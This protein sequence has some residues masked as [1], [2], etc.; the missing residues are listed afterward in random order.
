MLAAHRLEDIYVPLRLKE[1]G[2]VRVLD[3]DT[4]MQ[5]NNHLLILG[6]P[7]AG[8]TTLLK[9]LALQ[10]GAGHVTLREFVHSG[11]SLRDYKA[12]VLLLD[13][14]DELTSPENRAQALG[15]IHRFVEQY[16]RCRMVVTSRPTVSPDQLRGFSRLR[17]LEFDGQQIGQFIDN[18]SGSAGRDRANLL[19][20][21]LW[22]HQ[23]IESLAKNPLLLSVMA[24][25][26]DEGHDLMQGCAPL[27]ERITHLMLGLWDAH[28]K[29][30]NR[31][32]ADIKRFVL[33]K[34]AFRS[35]RLHRH[36]ITEEEIIEEMARHSGKINLGQEAFFPLLEEIWQRSGLLWPVSEESYEFFHLSFQ[37]YFTALEFTE[38]NDRLSPIIPYLYKP[39][40]ETPTLLYMEISRQAAPFI[41]R[42]QEEIPEDIFYSNLMLS[43][44]CLAAAR[45]PDPV[46]KGEIVQS[47]WQFYHNSEF[48][49]LKERAISVLGRLK[50]RSI[51][52][53]QVDKLTDNEPAVR[54]QAAEMLGLIGGTDTLTPLFMVLARD[55]DLKVRSSAASA[56][57]RVGSPEVVP[58][59]VNALDGDKEGE[60]R[61]SVAEA[62]GY[63]GSPAALPALVKALSV[64]RDNRVRGGA[65][66]A[67][68]KIGNPR[69]LSLLLQAFGTEQEVSVRWRIARSLGY[70]AGIDARDVLIAALVH[71]KNKEVRESAAE[72]LGMIGSP[73]C[74]KPLLQTLSSDRDGDVRGSAAYALGLIGSAEAVPELIKTFTTDSDV[75]VRGRAAF[76]LGRLKSKAA[77]PHLVSIFNAHKSSMFRGN[78]AYAL[79]EIAAE[80]AVP[81]LI[82]VLTLDADPYVRYRSAEV[83]GKI[84]DLMTVSPLKLALEDDGSY[85]GWKVKDKAFEALENLSQRLDIRINKD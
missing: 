42:I 79:G 19:L 67:L 15:E 6:A 16:P 21:L 28:K 61:Q 44:K 5:E 59:L 56:I 55:D 13:G 74:L 57:A 71:D 54:K 52:D 20:R 49:L 22:N 68:G 70:F 4:A 80:E 40:W 29:M 66:E 82:Q 23:S 33:M 12:S 10:Y 18:W 41:R 45:D 9:Y 46:L 62:L 14:L 50:P 43:G 8:K 81:F 37:E 69:A 32:P 51:I 77:I 17:L 27:Y 64:D 11:K 76:A 3:A 25:L 84:G 31:F 2:Q 60:V 58:P 65:A 24:T 63:I 34:L 83:L 75:E 48:Q 38:S 73:E 47:L 53:A 35:H 78:I 7:G 26:Y 30:R 39:W 72:G 36:T 85:Y 1:I